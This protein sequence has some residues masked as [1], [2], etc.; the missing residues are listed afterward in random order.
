M[1]LASLLCCVLVSRGVFGQFPEPSALLLEDVLDSSARYFPQVLESLAARR[2]AEGERLEAEGAFDL[3]FSADGNQ[4]AGYYDST[5]LRGSARQRLRTA[6]GSLYADYKLSSGN[7]PV[8]QDNYYTNT[9][10]TFRVGMLF[11]LLRDRNIDSQ[12][13]GVLD[14]RLSMQEADLDLLMTRVGVQERALIAYW[15]W[16]ARGRQ[17]QVYEELL[18]IARER[19]TGLEDEVERGA[20]AEIFLTEN[21]QNIT[22][23]QT[24]VTSAQ[25][26]LA[27]ATNQLSLYYRDTSGQPLLVGPQRLPPASDIE[28]VLAESAP[29]AVPVS[30]ALN[31][32]PELAMLKAAI[33]REQNRISLAENSLKPRL[34]FFVEMQQG[35]GAPAEGGRSRDSTDAMAGFTFSIPL[36][37][38]SARGRLISARADLE[39]RQFQQQLREEQIELEIRNLLVDLN[40]SRELLILADQEVQQSELMRDS[41]RRRFASGASD[42]FLLNIREETATNARIRLLEAEFQARMARASYDAAT[43][44]TERL[45]L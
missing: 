26:D 11:S 31:R 42:F 44:D 29:P 10:G 38:R 45:G 20:R 23:R 6:G 1:H 30:E 2:A 9:G 37:Q 4:N 3:V 35:L 28:A 36:Q 39:T 12:R 16:V 27:L 7:F 22:R 32:R 33:E 21:R 13:F 25:R 18:Q 5:S 41:E 40:I 17:L 43:V 24:L 19:Q 8:Y 14:A 15:D 34:D